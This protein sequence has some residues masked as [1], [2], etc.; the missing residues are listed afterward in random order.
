MSRARRPHRPALVLGLVA[1]GVACGAC[2]A[3]GAL[4]VLVTGTIGCQRQLLAV[5]PRAIR[6][7]GASRPA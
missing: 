1:A 7:R 3:A 5:P 2:A 4:A 6:S